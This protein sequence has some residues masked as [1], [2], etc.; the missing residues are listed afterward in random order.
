MQP[1][2]KKQKEEKTH[3]DTNQPPKH[4]EISASQQTLPMLSTT[5]TPPLQLLQKRTILEN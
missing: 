5:K 2:K 1:Y 3:M 4:I